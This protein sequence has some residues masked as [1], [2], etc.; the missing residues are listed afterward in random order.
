MALNASNDMA[1]IFR[2]LEITLTING[3]SLHLFIFQQMFSF[4]RKKYHFKLPH[5]RLR[6][7]FFVHQQ[8]ILKYL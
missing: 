1:N 4:L 8:D 7:F 3:I 6:F 2:E 5:T